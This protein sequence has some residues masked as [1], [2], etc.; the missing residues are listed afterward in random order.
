MN[1]RMYFHGTRF[2]ASRNLKISSLIEKSSSQMTAL[3]FVGVIV[4]RT[5][6]VRKNNL[7]PPDLLRSAR[8]PSQ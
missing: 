8:L 3:D 1:V 7:S 6:R 2:Y 4:G 5:C